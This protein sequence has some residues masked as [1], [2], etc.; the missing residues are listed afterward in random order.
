MKAYKRQISM[1]KVYLFAM[2]AFSAT[3]SQAQYT[4]TTL[5]AKTLEKKISE[6]DLTSPDVQ[7]KYI[8]AQNEEIKTIEGAKYIQI[9]KK[10]TRGFWEITEFYTNGFL[11]MEG[12]LSD[13]KTGLKEGKFRYYRLDG[14]LDYEGIYSN[15]VPDDEW[16]Y[17]FSNGQMSAIKVY[18]NGTKIRQNYWNE[19]GSVLID[20]KDAERLLPSFVGG[21]YQLYAY[22]KNNIH[23]SNP[24]VSG[25]LVVSFFVNENGDIQ[26]PKIEE[27][28]E[29]SID[30]EVLKTIKSM[31]KWIPAK[32]HNRPFRQMYILPVVLN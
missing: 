27:S 18:D 22:L 12:T 2:F 30:K 4:E 16:K 13:A 17:Y 9:L 21:Q 29:E 26:E 5:Y 28:L 3:L 31:P 32:H 19:D 14:T 20:T 25:K 6:L 10:N 15:N 11:R 23:L 24:K 7:K 1:K 8:N